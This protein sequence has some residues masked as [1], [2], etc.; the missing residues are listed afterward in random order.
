MRIHRSSPDE[1]FTIVPNDALRDQRLSYTARGV[2]AE[3]LTHSDGWETSADALWRLAQKNRGGKNGEGRRAI[4]A[5]FAELEECGYMVRRKTQN[6]KGRFVTVLEVYDTPGHRD[7]GSGTSV[8]D[9][10][11]TGYET[12]VGETSVGETSES[13]TSLRSTNQR[14]TNERSTNEEHSTALADA[15]AAA[16]AAR[17]KSK[18]E[19]LYESVNRLADRDLRNALLKFERHR[20]RIYRKCRNQAIEQMEKEDMQRLRSDRGGETIDTLSYKY[21]LL[22][23]H[24][25]ADEWPAWLIRPLLAVGGQA[26]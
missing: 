18:L 10:R 4:R 12:S 25:H 26:A 21:A 6:A 13:G 14:S 8:W 23:Y 3:L 16:I 9:D 24:L 19:D 17:K 15:R 20:P 11:G 5:A 1:N 22:H 2:L 7:A